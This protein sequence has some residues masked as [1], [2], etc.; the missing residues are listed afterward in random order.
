MSSDLIEAGI[1]YI[2]VDG[3]PLHR[4]EI[5]AFAVS[6]G[7]D[8]AR[9]QGIAPVKLIGASARE[10]MG[11]FWASENPGSLFQ[12]VIIRWEART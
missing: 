8:P 6:D 5:E 11:R 9:L 10:T 12:G 4:D 2:E 7:F 1:A 3:T